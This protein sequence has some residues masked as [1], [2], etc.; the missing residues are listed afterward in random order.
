MVELLIDVYF[1]LEIAFIF[2]I[3]LFGFILI[4]PIMKEVADE[5]FSSDFSAGVVALCVTL[6]SLGYTF[7]FA[8]FMITSIICLITVFASLLS[9]FSLMVF[10]KFYRVN[11]FLFIFSVMLSILLYYILPYI[12]QNMR[13]LDNVH[14]LII[15]CNLVNEVIYLIGIVEGA[16]KYIYPLLRFEGED[17]AMALTALFIITWI[18]A[19]AIRLTGVDTIPIFQETEDLSTI[20]FVGGGIMGYIV[21]I[22]RRQRASIT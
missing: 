16:V 11:K 14:N 18:L 13:T 4:F 6:A 21:L 8:F 5:L 7:Y 19:V 15:A 3:W 9:G 20:V 2:T 10:S 17:R 22:S 1:F 12:I